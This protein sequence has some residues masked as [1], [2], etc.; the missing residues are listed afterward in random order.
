MCDFEALRTRVVP[1]P[2][3]LEKGDGQ[4]LVLT[5]NSK[6]RIAA[7]SAE[8]GPIKGATEKLTAYLTKYCGQDCFAEDG[9]PVK[10]TLGETPTEAAGAEGGYRLCISAQGVE[11]TGFDATGVLYGVITFTQLLSWDAEG[12]HLPAL[13]VLDWPES[14]FRG[15]KQ[16]CRY[17]SNVMERE[18]WLTMLDEMVDKKMN[19]LCL[20]L[21][22]CWCVQY[23]GRVSEYLYIPV[24]KH[25]QLQT[26]MVIKYFSPEEN[27]WIECEKLP[28]IFCNNLLEEIFSRCRDLGIKLCPSWNSFGHNTLLPAQIGEISAKEEDGVTP[29]LTGFC[30]SNEETYKVLFGIYDQIIDD[31][32][33]PYGMDMFNI[34][35]DEVRD[36][37]GLNA[38]DP[39]RIRSPWCKCEKCRDKE[40]GDIFIQHA[41]KVVSYLKQK[42][43]KSAIMACDMLLANRPKSLGW[44]GDRLMQAM[45]EADLT[46]TLLINWWAYFDHVER[47]YFDN[48]HPEL[49]LRSVSIPWSGYYNW[50]LLTNPM[51]CIQL[52]AEMNHR[53]GG[54]GVYAYAMWDRS[55]DRMHDATADYGWD[56]V[57]SGSVEETT[58]RYVSRHFG[59]RFDEARH[60]YKLM[61]W[62]TEERKDDFTT[63]ISACVS[64]FNMLLYKLS[65]YTYSY[66]KA[67]KPYPRNFPGEPLGILLKH[68]RDFE[69]QLYSIASMSKEAIAIFRDLALDTRCDRAMAD[70]MACECENYQCLVE[71]YIA[72]LKM[73]DLTQSGDQK[74]IAPLARARQHARLAL[75]A[76][77]QRTK[78]KFTLEALMMRNQSIFMQM[79]ADIADYIETA[80]DPKLDLM[81]VSG[82]MSKR[83]FDLR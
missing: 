36:E 9:L 62:I 73:Y 24:K 76:H 29:T 82:I 38:Q 68:R 2:K 71:D 65:Y 18:D 80:D 69:R 3:K 52:N 6:F 34:L 46:D 43:I 7:P 63:P 15:I 55:Y 12:A 44:L 83:F 58:D 77:Y 57:Q 21:Y 37:P 31:Y 5:P 54:E 66:V 45:E 64:N 32:M 8:F 22:G 47:M 39:T 51:R 48:V 50:C 49:G 28:P 72:L 30:T 56:Y 23:D 42:G 75:M 79:F 11:I 17:G 19:F 4:A 33:K 59:A 1:I 10:L 67:D 13:T 78:E 40:K 81:D 70:R 20:G 14:K 27:R 74:Q 35:L 25:P 41:V 61:D 60:A 26:P 16:E 53:D